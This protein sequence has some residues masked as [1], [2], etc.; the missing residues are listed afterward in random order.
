MIKFIAVT[1]LAFWISIASAQTISTSP[2][3]SAT[4]SGAAGGG[5]TGTYPN[6]T[7]A[8]V[9]ATALGGMSQIVNV[10]GAPVALNNT[11]N[12]FDG[13][14]IA[15]GSTGT[16]F[17]SGS[18]LVNDAGVSANIICKLWDGTTIISSGGGNVVA[19]AATETIALSGILASPASNI[20]ISCRDVTATTGN[21]LSNGTGNSKDSIITAI[22]IQ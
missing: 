12:Y 10:L 19:A 21:I 5:L 6:P 7:V 9:P 17:A 15:Q 13:P 16:W 18:V 14:S 22:R 4:P 11:S 8:T 3:T 2:P 1:I 20:R